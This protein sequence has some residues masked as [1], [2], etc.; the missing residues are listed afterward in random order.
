MA[1][2][3]AVEVFDVAGLIWFSRMD[4]LGTRLHALMVRHRIHPMT[5]FSRCGGE[6]N[7]LTGTLQN[8]T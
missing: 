8:Y 6:D 7:Q 5:F 2:N 1:L 3:G 4:G